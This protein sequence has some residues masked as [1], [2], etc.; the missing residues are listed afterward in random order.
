MKVF[1]LALFLVS[2]SRTPLTDPAKA[3]L[4]AESAPELRDSYPIETLREAL[5]NTLAAF[6][7]GHNIPAT[8]QFAGRTIARDDYRRALEALEPELESFE[9]FHSFVRENFEF[10]PVY[11]GDS[12]GE[13]LSTGYF[14]AALKGSRKQGGAFTEPLYRAPSDMVSVDLKAFADRLPDLKS[15]QSLLLESVSKTPSWR[16]RLVKEGA[17]PRVVPYYSRSEIQRERVLAKRGLEIVYVDPIDEFFLEIQGSGTVSLDGGKE[18]RVGYDSQ[19]GAP[20]TPIG[21]FLW[22]II[23]KEKMSMQRIRAHLTTLDRGRQQDLFDKNASYVFFKELRGAPV[24]YCGAEVTPNRTIASDQ[25]LFPKGVLEFL[26]VDEPVFAHPGDLDPTSWEPRPR[27]VFDQDTGGAIRG[28]GRIDLY[29]GRGFDA[30][31]VAGVMKRPGKLWGLA[32]KPEFLA[33]L[34]AR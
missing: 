11:G 22:D 30:E 29:T 10:L 14:D 5:K 17:I 1:L 26:I 9:R 4:P 13:V 21:R 6:K 2:C 12:A 8:F 27:W 20:Y 7:A 15:L 24:T 34:I 16:G 25:G 23:P 3:F 28:G 33:K 19:N 32:P 18:I 31:R